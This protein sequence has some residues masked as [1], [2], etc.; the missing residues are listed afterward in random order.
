MTESPVIV[1][2]DCA[3]LMLTVTTCRCVHG[4]N[5]L[6]VDADSPGGQ[7]YWDCRLCGGVGTVADDCPG[8]RGRGRVRAHLVVTV[9]NLDSGAVASRVFERTC[10]GPTVPTFSGTSGIDGRLLASCSGPTS[11]SVLAAASR[12]ARPPR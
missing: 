1:C 7:P 5:R 6:V 9:A 11:P 12:P 8:C 2:P 4:G 3:G 10:S